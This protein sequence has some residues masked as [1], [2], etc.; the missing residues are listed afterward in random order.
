MPVLFA[1]FLSSALNE[2]GKC[3][4]NTQVACVVVPSTSCS[5]WEEQTLRKLVQQTKEQLVLLHHQTQKNGPMG[6][7]RKEIPKNEGKDLQR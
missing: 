7:L 3:S 6:F 4:E 5:A 2:M 1:E